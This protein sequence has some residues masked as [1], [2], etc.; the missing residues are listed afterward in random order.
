MLQAVRKGRGWPG[1][2]RGC[3]RRQLR[4]AGSRGVWRGGWGYVEIGCGRLIVKLHL[5]SESGWIGGL[6]AGERGFARAG[7]TAFRFQGQTVW[8]TSQP[9]MTGFQIWAQIRRD[10]AFVLN[11][12][13]RQT[14]GGINRAVGQDA[15]CGAGIQTAGAGTAAVGSK[16]GIGFDMSVEEKFRQQE[17]M[18]QFPG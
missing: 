6:Q 11:R 9:K 10:L 16:G 4:C 18:N 2:G 5:F 1:A 3:P 8:Q 17:G 14:T 13:V 12:Q 7:R 15:G